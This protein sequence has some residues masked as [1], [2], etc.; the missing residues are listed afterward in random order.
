MTH[1]AA[2]A[3]PWIQRWSHLLA[4]G[5]PVLDLACGAGRHLHWF[6]TRGHSVLGVDLDIAP[7]QAVV[8]AHADTG[9]VR[10]VQADLEN[11]AWP[12]R[13]A[14]GPQ[15]FGGVI[16]TNY[17]WRALF[18]DIL[19]SLGPGGV[20]LYETFAHGNARFGRP[21]RAEFLLQPGELL[22]LCSGLR[23][24]A[25]EDGVLEQPLRQVQR[26][27]ALRLPTATGA[28]EGAEHYLL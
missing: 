6:A 20:L 28:N 9:R 1:V 7:A 23:V 11:A 18:P 16:V 13:S 27:A 4:P 19:S 21:A 24:V 3:S 5:C 25:Y 22:R 17:L 10:V 15:S 26:I 8:D 2:Q 14:H 12:L